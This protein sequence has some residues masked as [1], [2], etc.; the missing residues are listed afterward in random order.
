MV[1]LTIM[2]L[3]VVGGLG[4]YV[5][6]ELIVLRSWKGLS[7]YSKLVL[8]ITGALI[9]FGTLLTLGV[10]WNN[11]ATL[12]GMSTGDKV[13]NALFQSVTL[14]TA[15]YC[16]ID[17]AALQD[18]SAAVSMLLMLIGGS[19]GSTAGGIK[20]VTAGV[21]LLTVWSSLRGREQV[22]VK[23]R[24]IPARKVL[25]AVTL[26]VTVF[27]LLIFGSMAL[28]VLD[29]VPM[30]E[31]GYEVASAL[32]TV[33]L[34]MGVTPGLSAGSSLLIILYMFLGR[35]GILSFSIAFLIRRADSKL[36]YPDAQMLIG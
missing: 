24:T 31:A 20:T 7:L 26:T 30:L 14:R 19:S 6:E 13:L 18:S 22:V 34:S 28:S 27:A 12:G 33:G 10:E 9:V 17:Q 4:F 2:T 5:W 1:L 32:G 36:R 29:G 21:L 8:G 11:P 15:G 16:T 25:D 3:I 23:G 35:V